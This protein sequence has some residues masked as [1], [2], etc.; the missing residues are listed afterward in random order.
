MLLLKREGSKK[1]AH[2][3]ICT[4]ASITRCD[5]KAASDLLSNKNN[6]STSIHFFH[7]AQKIHQAI[8]KTPPPP[9]PSSYSTKTTLN[10]RCNHP[11]PNPLSHPAPDPLSS[12]PLSFPPPHDR[13]AAHRPIRKI[14]RREPWHEWRAM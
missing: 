5:T 12:P 13:M 6:R 1:R 10:P 4:S 8:P 3:K 9:S 14:C 7:F 2:Y 11:P